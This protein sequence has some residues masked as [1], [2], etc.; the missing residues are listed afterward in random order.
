M[1]HRASLFGRVNA[2]RH[3][4]SA[5]IRFRRAL[6]LSVM[7][8]VLP[9]SA[10]LLMGRK[11]LGRAVLAVWL[12]TVATLIAGVLVLIYRR[13]QAISFLTDAGNLRAIQIGLVVIA[14]LWLL[15]FVDAWRLGVRGRLRRHHLAFLT[16]FNTGVTLAAVAAFF[17]AVQ[18]V[19]APR[20]VVKE[21]FTATETSAPQQGRYNVLLLGSDSGKGRFSLRP[22]S[23]T[24]LSVD[25][26]TG[27]SA[28][29][30]LPRNL[31]NVPFPEDS[32]MRQLYPYGFNCEECLLN[33][34]Y[35]VASGQPNLYPNSD[36]PGMDATIEA[37][38]EV[39]GLKINY[40]ILINMKGFDTLVDAVG[41]VEINVKD[42][43]AIDGV[44]RPIQGWIEPGVQLLDG[45]E[46]LWFARSRTGT[47]D[48]TRMGRQKCVM[49]AMVQQLSPQK[50]L[51]NAQKLSSSSKEMLETDI[52]ASEL[53]LF[54]ELA[55]K[56]RGTKIATTSFVPPL[57][58]TGNPDFG[59]IR[60]LVA[61]TITKSEASGG[62][63]GDGS[64]EAEPEASA[65]TP[66]YGLSES[67]ARA[68]EANATDDL[69]AVC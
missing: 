67:A 22:D 6:A 43:V 4:D 48:F 2:D 30:S 15:L 21:V 42:R 49:S 41:G 44:G 40:H 1:S 34:V 45:R 47:D 63:P 5:R 29:I 17:F 39:T 58:N 52:P 20:E 61:E 25:R 35:T 53:D 65:T 60:E 28:L 68:Q 27:K 18:L 38:E 12:L 36:D 37:I 11:R 50:V 64:V 62:T 3:L 13:S 66:T 19:N 10:Q 31:Q 55:L 46:T 24:V 56:T 32:P 57:I 69:A 54:I 9:G 8:V 26:A 51:F 23:M 33:A 59:K 7:T 16:F 14:F